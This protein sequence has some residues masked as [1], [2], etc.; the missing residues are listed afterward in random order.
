MLKGKSKNSLKLNDK[1]KSGAD[2]QEGEYYIYVF[3]IKLN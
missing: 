3:L 1:N 2:N